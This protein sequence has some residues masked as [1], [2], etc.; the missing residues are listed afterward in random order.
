MKTIYYI[1]IF[2]FLSTIAHG[3]EI[4]CFTLEPPEQILSGIQKIA[5]MDFS[6]SYGR[7]LSDYLISA[8]LESQRGI[9]KIKGGI[10][11]S[12]KEG[13][14]YLNG[15]RTDI[16]TLVER[17]R[18]DAVLKE[19]NLGTSG[20]VDEGQAANLG[21]VLGV[22][23]IIIGT[24]NP[25]SDDSNTR[26]ER[27]YKKD[28]QW[29]SYYEDCTTRKVTVDSRMRI[30]NV[31]TGQIIGTRAATYKAEDKQCADNRSRLI[32]SDELI[33]Q[34]VQSSVYQNFVNYVAPRFLL[35]E[36][37]VLEIDVDAYEDLSDKAIEFVDK[38]N[39]DRAYVIYSGILK[40]DPYNDVVQ[41]NLGVLNEVV[42]NYQTALDFYQAAY[43]I[44]DDEDY[45]DALNNVNRCLE[46]NKAL[47]S[48][49]VIIQPY[50]YTVSEEQLKSAT[51]QK[52]RLTGN[53]SDRINLYNEPGKA[54]D[55]VV[56]V[57][58]GI[59]LEL[60]ERSGKWYKVKTF[61][62]KIGYVNEDDLD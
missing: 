7:E 39:F 56:K 41:Y 59:E 34:C 54:S 53:K 21:K 57:P 55:I 40:E 38:D 1:I 50:N 13:K 23:A 32:S 42:G 9:T 27:K 11:S 22:D 28:G 4:K 45:A 2:L 19:Q 12:D 52:I 8:L 14:T 24:V 30:V 60:I 15:A 58:G 31:N 35:K 3:Q 61:D 5:V 49:N 25:N 44:R 6:G 43:N 62:G 46:L 26:E 48:L 29:Y 18:L 20:I 37:E 51:T 33:K 17:S 16:Y 10:F 36:F 47:A